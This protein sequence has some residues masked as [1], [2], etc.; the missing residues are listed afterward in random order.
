MRQ[1]GRHYRVR[2]QLDGELSTRTG[3]SEPGHPAMDMATRSCYW[4]DAVAGEEETRRVGV[5]PHHLMQGGLRGQ[6][7]MPRRVAV[8]LALDEDYEPAFSSGAKPPDTVGIR[9]SPSR[10]RKRSPLSAT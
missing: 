6:V 2:E 4:L 9:S 5:R 7:V 8:G 10:Q 1:L 3:W